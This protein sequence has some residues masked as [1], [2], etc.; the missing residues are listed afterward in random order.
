[1]AENIV[2]KTFQGGS[3]T[4]QDDAIMQQTAIPG[5]GI[6]KGCN[7]SYARGNILRVSPGFGM[8]CG[9]FFEVYE[10]EVAVKLADGDEVLEGRIYIHLDLSNADEPIQIL[11]DAKE[12]LPSLEADMDINYN[13][14]VFELELA[15]FKVTSTDVSELTQ[16]FA[17]IASSGGGGGKSSLSRQTEY[18]VGD[19][20]ESALAPG[21]VTLLCSTTG[22]T[23][24]TEPSGYT[25]ITKVGDTVTDG[26]AVFTARNILSE[27]DTAVSTLSGVETEVAAIKASMNNTG[28]LSTMV[29]SV[30]EYAA[31]EGWNDNTIYFCYEDGTPSKIT[32]IFKGEARIYADAVKVTYQYE[33]TEDT[34]IKTL[35]ER[36]DAILAAPTVTKEDYTFVGWRKDTEANGKILENYII[37][38]DTAVTLYAVFKRD[39]EIGMHPN[40]G[41][42]IDGSSE[43][44]LKVSCFYNNGNSL[45]SDVI[46]PECPYAKENQTFCGWT[47]NGQLY[48]PGD[49]GAFTDDGIM[50][51]TWIDTEYDFPYSS[52]Y[53]VFNIPADGIYEFEVFGAE[54]F[55]A[56]NGTEKAMGGKG[57]HAKGYKKMTKGDL[58]YVANGGKPVNYSAG[59]NN[60]G[61]NGGIYTNS[62]TYG[63]S[64]G[65][66]TC[67]TTITNIFGTYNNSSQYYAK[68]AG[69]LIVAGG[70]GGGGIVTNSDGTLMLNKGGDGG[71]DRGEDGSDGALG[72]RQVSTGSYEYTNYGAA[73]YYSSSSTT[74]SG[75][76]G[77]YFGGNYALSGKS[78][79]GGSGYVGGVPAF[80]HKKKYYGTVNEVGVH[81]GNGK[82]YIRYMDCA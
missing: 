73:P 5:N 49:K 17:K 1:M 27:M 68:R 58:V 64:G 16:V 66:A 44:T 61:G 53:V 54:G 32:R 35:M 65:G 63:A 40:G 59:G 12:T 56:T 31:M 4:P 81:E 80:T 52:S 8:I 46:L 10:A 50:L 79:A 22:V 45:S 82:A 24:I 9:R 67:I 43:S 13:N 76:G 11:T 25:K 14:S 71:G 57:G 69:V 60:G 51:A 33:T 78:G 39:I 19:S 18:Q 26:T 23:A 2:L 36:E 29:C 15:T 72:G 62:K 7:I 30:S 37:A 48:K 20:A 6:F 75:G 28:A 77:G 42:V 70:G 55:Y 47:Y 34:I 3:V 38:D 21:W 41:A 74:I